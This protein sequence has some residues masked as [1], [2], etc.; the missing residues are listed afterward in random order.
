MACNACRLE[1]AVQGAR[2]S[3]TA[4]V[5]FFTPAEILTRAREAGFREVR[6][7]SAANLGERYFAGQAD[8]LRPVENSEVLLAA[9]T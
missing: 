1:R 2:T 9:T 5:S 8:G 6:H 3:G 7:V 4:F